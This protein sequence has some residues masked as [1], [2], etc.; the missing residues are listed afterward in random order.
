MM[1]V[2]GD[3][4][5]LR[6]LAERELRVPARLHDYQ[7]E[8]IAFL[9]RSRAALLADEMG[10]GK[11]VQTAVALALLLQARDG[12]N[13]AIIVAPAS[14]TLNWM[15]EL[16][17]WTPSITAMRV[18][19]DARARKAYYLLPV[20]VLVASYEQIRFDALDRIPANTFD[21]VVLDEAQRIKN[22]NSATAFACRLLPRVRAWA[23]TATP[24]ENTEADVGSILG[25][26][27]PSAGKHLSKGRIAGELKALML[28]RR[29]AEVRSELPPVIVQDLEISLSDPQREAYDA[30]W[31]KRADALR[32]SCVQDI[33]TAMLSLITRLKILCNFDRTSGASSKLDA[34]QAFIE[35]AGD[36]ARV[37]IFSQFV[38]TLRWISARLE[39][40]HECLTGSMTVEARYEAITAFKEKPAPRA[41][42]TSL[43][44]GGVGLNL[45]DATHVV[46]F[47][48]WWN[49][50]VE[51]Q[52]IFR[53]HRFDREAP[54]HVVR[55]L[56]EDTIE[57]RIAE[58]LGRKENLFNE[59]VES[60]DTP[61]YQFTREELMRILELSPGDLTRVLK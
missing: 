38:E 12:I 11:T 5:E 10:L 58:I 23:L 56:V 6:Q 43:R 48:R 60:V 45:G 31:F 27:D 28:R 25:F 50:A 4:V 16:A 59:I 54:L 30:L 21:L 51:K 36:N 17:T 41:L 20:P 9:Y 32:E 3:I 47:D 39:I 52:A 29:K 8:G 22:P 26:L 15:N 18:S 34:L 49:P 40:D 7:W 57:E 55:F 53:A 37:L 33:E 35:G 46:L 42:L 1:T 44:V 2:S 24:L 14:L 19:G 13:R 61:G